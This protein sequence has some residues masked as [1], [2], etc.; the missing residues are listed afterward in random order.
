MSID[1]I[2]ID[3]PN[4]VDAFGNPLPRHRIDA[5]VEHQRQEIQQLRQQL[6]QAEAEIDRLIRR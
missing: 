3:P 4:V 1:Y 5:L 2:K 6:E